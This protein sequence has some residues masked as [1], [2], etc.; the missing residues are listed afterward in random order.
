MMALKVVREILG[1]AQTLPVPLR[2]N[3]TKQ[4]STLSPSQGASRTLVPFLHVFSVWRKMGRAFQK[5]L[6]ARI[7]T[8]V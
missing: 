6:Y 7:S 3:Q 2:S 8:L 4:A 1:A 5:L